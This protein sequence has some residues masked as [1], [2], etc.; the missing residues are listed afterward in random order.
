MAKIKFR[1]TWICKFLTW[2]GGTF[3]K[4]L[5]PLGKGGLYMS[6]GWDQ[7]PCELMLRGFGD[8]SLHMY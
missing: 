3:I 2:D 6:Q 4:K 1:Y 8:S 5:L 7:W